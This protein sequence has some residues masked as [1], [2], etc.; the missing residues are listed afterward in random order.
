MGVCQARLLFIAGLRPDCPLRPSVRS[1]GQ[2]GRFG[3]TS[4]LQAPHHGLYRERPKVS[5][6]ATRLDRLRQRGQCARD[7]R[8]ARV[9]SSI[10]ALI[11]SL[12]GGVELPD[13]DAERF[14]CGRDAGV[15]RSAIAAIAAGRQNR[16]KNRCKKGGQPSWVSHGAG[17]YH[18]SDGLRRPNLARR[19]P[20]SAAT[21]A[22]KSDRRTAD[23]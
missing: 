14:W 11:T 17:D 1:P 23:R 8:V 9:A 21:A 7:A 13:A 10:T 16:E 19:A 12:C 6:R 15:R 22:S 4:V 2:R 5:L 18:E 3:R 20:R